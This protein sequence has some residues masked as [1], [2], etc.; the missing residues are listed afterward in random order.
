M[1]HLRHFAKLWRLSLVLVV[2]WYLAA[3]GVAPRLLASD[4]GNGIA[5][6]KSK[7][8]LVPVPAAQPLADRSPVDIASSARVVT[9]D[10]NRIKG[11]VAKRND[12]LPPEDIFLV[13]ELKPKSDGSYV[14]PP[15]ADGRSTIGLEWPE[16]RILRRLELHWGDGAAIPPADAVQL[17][18][19]VGFQGRGKFDLWYDN[20]SCAW[21]G[22]WKPLV[23]QFEK[24]PGV[25]RW[26]ITNDAQ[27]E[28]PNG[29]YRVRWV[30]PASKQPFVVK[31]VS[32]FT[33]TSWATTDLRVE[34]QTPN[35]GKHVPISIINGEFATSSSEAAVRARDWDVARPMELKVRYSLPMSRKNDRTVLRF[36]LPRQTVSVAVED[37]LKNGCVY[38]PSAGLFVTS[39]PPKATL[40]EY[41][42]SIAGKKTVLEEVRTQPD[43]T[44]AQAMSKLHHA[45]QDVGPMFASLACDNRKYIVHRS[46]AIQF[47]LYDAPDGEYCR[48]LTWMAKE[49]DCTMEPVFGGGKGQLSRHLDGGWLPKP[50]TIAVEDGVKYR[51][52]TYMAPIDEKSP[53]GCPNWYR[54]RAVCV[55][56]Y[57][58]KNT[59][60]ID[61]AV[62][63]KLKFSSKDAK[64]TPNGLQQVKNSLLLTVGDRVAACVD[65]G[66]SSLR[67]TS[68]G[69]V[70][71]FTGKLGAG[72]SARLVV[73]LPGWPVKRA[74]YAVL[75][76]PTHWA[77]ALEQYWNDQ[78][79]GATQIDIPDRLLANVIRA[80][81]MHCMLV[82]RNQERGRYVEPW[83]APMAFGPIDLETSAVIRGMDM[84]GQADFARR[85]MNYILDKRYNKDGFFTTGYTLSGMGIH[86]WVLGE[87]CIRCDDR[88]WL[89]SVAPQLV[90]AC[91]WIADQR[92]LTKRNDAN[93]CKMPEYGLMPPGVNG[94]YYRFAYSFFNDSQFCYGLEMIGR[95]LATIGDPASPAIL[96]EA[97][98]HR[99]DVIRA[100][101]W[102]QSRCPVVALRNGTWIPN[103]PGTLAFVGN[104]EEMIPS[105]EDAGRAWCDDVE[106]GSHH[107][108]ANRILDPFSSDVVW[109]LDFIEDRQFLRSGWHDFPEEQNRKDVFNFGGFGKVQPYYVRNAEIYAM[110]DDVKPFL[111]SYF[112]A[113]SAL[114]NQETLY[115]CEHFANAGAPDKTHETG[116]F[117]CQTATMFAVDR[118]D[119]LWLAPMTT[120]R[121]LKDGKTI[122]VRNLPTRF[123][124][125]A[126][127]IVSHV[128]DGYAEASVGSPTRN[129]PKHVVIRVRHPEGKRIKAVTVDGKP[130][131]DFDPKTE[132]VRLAPAGQAIQIRVEY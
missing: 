86:L 38:V 79:A 69:N 52:C 75:L 88:Q 2:C 107:L 103:H 105:N 16:M 23:A 32:A 109:M 49:P 17:Q 125:V 114:L 76:N 115:L 4:A 19:W 72:K 45:A 92:T 102:A 66:R 118:G 29:T 6:D 51:Q 18:Y 132:T 124:P 21:Q 67:L 110:Q 3:E 78:L 37:V 28:Q 12:P 129:P 100:F 121:W 35:A 89:T 13:T 1:L 10:P 63:L 96:A 34:L 94:D 71:E 116:W 60:D 26:K 7:A 8:G 30:F 54:P 111:R 43:Q 59:K 58:V 33:P 62:S 56:E 83:V 106:T 98:Q 11:T 46:G 113:L 87:H 112:N 22:G 47:D 15:A 126:Y 97:K 95:S 93:G 39:N 61:A 84:C 77:G 85:G 5:T 24:S 123:G 70:V 127:K 73:Y 53:E 20:R 50:T 91:K 128:N 99:E 120:D 9:S 48:L 25:W 81:Q 27:K 55:A 42:Q 119:D 36:E 57:T 65:V 80:S 14:V 104:I 44:F 101:H 131:A 41:L 64:K 82:A 122:E 130:Y 117:L 40:A 108:A 68:K 90:K 31:K 74:G